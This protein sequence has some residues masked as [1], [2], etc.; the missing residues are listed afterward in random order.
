MKDLIESLKKRKFNVH[1]VKNKDEA[2]EKVLSLLKPGESI[3]WGGSMSC[4]ECGIYDA[5]RQ[6][7]D[8]TTVDREL[9]KTPEEIEKFMHNCFNATWFVTSANA[10]LTDGRIINIDGKGNRVAATIYGPEN[11]IFVIGKNKI[12]DGSLEEGI[13]RVKNVASPPNTKRLDKKTPCAVTGECADC[14]S[15]DRICRSVAIIEWQKNND[16]IHV[17]LVDEELG[18]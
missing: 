16:G 6:R 10:L 14:A 11:V 9:G 13:S 17:I 5:L 3:G 12:V 18:Y 4:K 8:I 2:R 7:E 15:P 1:Q